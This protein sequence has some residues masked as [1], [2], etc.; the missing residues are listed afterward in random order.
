MRP[1]TVTCTVIRNKRFQYKIENM[2][3]EL[4]SDNAKIKQRKII[5]V[6]F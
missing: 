5:G 3:H 2:T 4:T 1:V 6:Y